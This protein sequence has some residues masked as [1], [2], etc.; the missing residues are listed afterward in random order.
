M[1]KDGGGCGTKG[2]PLKHTHYKSHQRFVTLLRF[3]GVSIMLPAQWGRECAV[4]NTTGMN[5][6]SSQGATALFFLLS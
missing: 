3:S 6:S 5:K 2:T 4:K 1:T